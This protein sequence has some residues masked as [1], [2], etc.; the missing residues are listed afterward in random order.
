MMLQG[1]KATGFR[2]VKEMKSPIDLKKFNVVV[3][4]NNS[5]KSSLLQ[6]LYLFPYPFSIPPFTETGWQKVQEITNQFTSPPKGIT[7]LQYRYSGVAKIEWFVSPG[8]ITMEFHSSGPTE[9]FVR[10]RSAAA[11]EQTIASYL[12]GK[13]DQLSMYRVDSYTS[14]LSEIPL[15]SLINPVV[16]SAIERTEAPFTIASDFI[17]KCVNEHFTELS[18]RRDELVLRKEV[19]GS[20]PFYVKFSDMGDGVRRFAATLLL[21]TATTPQLAIWDDFDAH[22]HPSMVGVVLDYLQGKEWQVVL[23]THSI[24]ALSKLVDVYPKDSQVILLAKDENDIVSHR[25]LTIPEVEALLESNQD[26]RKLAEALSV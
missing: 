22:M 1:I 26:P 10:D 24:D 11:N 20:R 19:A 23:S 8:P 4:R 3:G 12:F 17:S 9:L 16:W 21:A 15:K 18:V 14:W 7:S 5:G 2:G 25:S 13:A 6:A